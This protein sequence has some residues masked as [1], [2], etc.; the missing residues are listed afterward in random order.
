MTTGSRVK[1]VKQAGYIAGIVGP[2]CLA[3]SQMWSAHEETERARIEAERADQCTD[4]YR[5][6]MAD[7][8]RKIEALR[9][10]GP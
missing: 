8:E 1:Q 6:A 2:I 7:L 9:R 4:D 3:A 10:G 5:E